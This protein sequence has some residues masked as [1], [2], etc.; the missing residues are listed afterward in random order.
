MEHRE[1]THGGKLY[2]IGETAKIMGISVQTLRNYS[3]FPFLQPAYVNEETGY[4]YY[5]FDQ[6]HII[7]RIKYLRGFDLS[8][9]EIQDIMMD[10]QKTDKII[11]YLEN[12]ETAL[13]QQIEDLQMQKQDLHWYLEYFQYLN[14]NPQNARPHVAHF[15]TRYVLRTP[16]SSEETIEDIEVRLAKLKVSYSDREIPFLRQFGYLLNFEDI[17][18]AKWDPTDYFIYFSGHS[19]L[20][21]L[22][23]ADPEH[24]LEFPAGDYLCFSFRLRHMKELNTNLIREY[25]KNTP[26]SPLVIA[27]EYED[28]LMTYKTCPYELQIFKK[29]A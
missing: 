18:D 8:L 11:R 7:D 26:S 3:K 12:R 1:D 6:F 24:I 14:Q 21:D 13:E 28:N 5:S 25:F 17:L 22:A 4:R 2:S 9:A 10:G 15:D 27:N 29:K 23:K 19:Q 20:Q 16:C